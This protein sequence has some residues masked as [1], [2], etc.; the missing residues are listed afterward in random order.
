V[1]LREVRYLRVML[2]LISLMNDIFLMWR[3]VT[4][5]SPSNVGL[6]NFVLHHHDLSLNSTNEL[7]PA[8][9]VVHHLL[10]L[11]KSTFSKADHAFAIDSVNLDQTLVDHSNVKRFED[12]LEEVDWS[13]DDPL[14]VDSSTCLKGFTYILSFPVLD[15]FISY[16]LVVLFLLSCEHQ[17]RILPKPRTLISLSGP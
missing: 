8:H 14:F 15:M 7:A 2:V 5:I 4:K 17:Y 1:S 3:D 6:M 12:P 11:S 10:D 13:F 9:I 16:V